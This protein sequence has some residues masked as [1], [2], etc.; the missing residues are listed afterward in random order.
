MLENTVFM[1]LSD[2]IGEIFF[3]SLDGGGDAGGG[4][5]FFFVTAVYACGYDV[6]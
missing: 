2:E 6:I 3:D 5:W 1:I 4:E